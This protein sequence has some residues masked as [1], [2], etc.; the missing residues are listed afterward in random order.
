M[1]LARRELHGK[2]RL[3]F[4]QLANQA[5]ERFFITKIFVKTHRANPPLFI[6]ESDR[7]N[8]CTPKLSN[9]SFV[10]MTIAR[11]GAD[12]KQTGLTAIGDFG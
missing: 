2:D 7:R 11:S 10:V 9:A 1:W 12:S 4:H 5:S 6:D 8:S 3:F